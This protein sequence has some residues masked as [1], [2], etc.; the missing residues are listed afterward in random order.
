MNCLRFGIVL[1]LLVVPK[2]LSAEEIRQVDLRNATDAKGKY[3]LVFCSRESPDITIPGHAFVVWAEENEEKM[4]SIASAYG[5]Y[6]A[7]GN[8]PRF[9]DVPASIKNEAT[10]DA[11]TKSDLLTHRLIVQVNK[12][13]YDAALAVMEDWK[14]KKY[15]LLAQ[16]CVDF[17]HAVA[18]AAGVK[19]PRPEKVAIPSRYFKAMFDDQR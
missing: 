8:K 9:G 17:T 15:N 13:K 18:V 1:A 4:M 6:P 7:D 16:N 19:A 5:F 3:F 2:L 14:D 11:S 10:V 12:D